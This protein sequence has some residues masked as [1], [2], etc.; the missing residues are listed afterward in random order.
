MGDS[1]SGRSQGDQFKMK[2]LPTFAF[3]GLAASS[4]GA[5]QYYGYQNVPPPPSYPYSLA[6]FNNPYNP[7]Q[8]V[9]PQPAV[10]TRTASNTV[11]NAPL[12]LTVDFDSSF[13]SFPLGSRNE[14]TPAQ[15]NILLPVMESLVKVME[16]DKPSVSDVNTLMIQIRDLLKQVPEGYVPNLRQFGLDVDSVSLGLD[17]ET[18]KTVALPET[19]DIAITE[20][21]Q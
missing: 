9:A 15:R 7:V 17:L 20:N 6:F 2:L 1:W 11:N 5:P 8:A 10:L 18:L 4:Y 13:G 3:L 14:L 21:G 12:G 19:G 16:S